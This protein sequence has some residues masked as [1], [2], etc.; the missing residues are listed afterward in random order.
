MVRLPA[1]IV[2]GLFTGLFSLSAGS[3]DIFDLVEIPAGQARLG[4][5]QGDGN[6]VV[7]T[8]DLPAFRMMRFEVT[9]AQFG[10]FLAESGY[11]TD[12]ER[13]GEGYTWWRRWQSV[14]GANWRQ[15]QGPASDI[16]D[17]EDHPVVQVSARDAEAFCRHY[18][19]RLPNDEEWE[20]AA[21]GTDGRR[22]P[23]GDNPPGSPSEKL[24]NAGTIACCGPDE[25]DGYARTAPVGSFPGGRS[26]FGLFDMAGNVW[27]WTASSFPGKPSE[28]ALRGG[29]WGNNPYCLRAAY[30]HGN[31][32][33]I[34]L[35]MVGFRCAGDSE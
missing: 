30:R 11:T 31:P 24:A 21:R 5:A 4:D 33:D 35:D 18:G 3:E 6:E 34:G 17:L 16:L 12:V 13:R 14:A 29:G 19:L 1:A 10:R 15:P 25:G 28:R 2:L 26:P 23:W 7:R 32:S 27:E 9:N 20:Y 8:F 22:F